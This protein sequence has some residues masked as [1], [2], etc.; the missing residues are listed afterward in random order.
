MIYSFARA[1]PSGACEHILFLPVTS[2]YTEEYRSVHESVPVGTRKNTGRYTEEYRSVHGRIPV[3]ARKS[4]GRC[5]KGYRSVH[6][7]VP[8]VYKAYPWSLR[9]GSLEASLSVGP[10]APYVPSEAAGNARD[11]AKNEKNSKISPN[12]L[13][14]CVLYSSFILKNSV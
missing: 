6:D 5:T 11:M 2:R 14:F 4:T 10:P 13:G 7:C 1:V 8:V 3:G 12:A 9:G